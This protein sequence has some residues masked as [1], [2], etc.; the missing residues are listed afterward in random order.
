LL[1]FNTALTK[2]FKDET[3][4]ETLKLQLIGILDDERMAEHIGIRICI[5]PL[6][7]SQRLL[8]LFD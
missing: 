5:K 3:D 7:K 8:Y 1:F 6:D 4:A 2:F